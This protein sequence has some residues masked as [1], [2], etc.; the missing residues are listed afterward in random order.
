MDPEALELLKQPLI[1]VPEYARVTRTG[2]NSAYEAV[3]RGDVEVM[4][5]GKQI[6]VL[7]APLRRKLG[8]DVLAA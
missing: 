8:I 4:R 1:T 2:R 6:R 7:T 5:V 3:Q